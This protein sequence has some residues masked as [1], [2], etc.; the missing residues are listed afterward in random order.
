M[1]TIELTDSGDAAF[2]K[3]GEAI[4]FFEDDHC[5]GVSKGYDSEKRGIILFYA[6]TV[7]IYG[8][9]AQKARESSD[10]GQPHRP[11]ALA[12]AQAAVSAY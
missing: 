2:L 3:L 6:Q 11:E 8:E 12:F 1:H 5:K 10:T 9:I 7:Q 4:R